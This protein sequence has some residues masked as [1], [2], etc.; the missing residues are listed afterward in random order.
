MG[1]HVPGFVVQL[2]H[3]LQGLKDATRPPIPRLYK[4]VESEMRFHV[5]RAQ[6][7][8]S[9]LVGSISRGHVL[10]FALRSEAPIEIPVN[11]NDQYMYNDAEAATHREVKRNEK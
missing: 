5:F 4:H 1:P 11:S 10:L 9:P 3:T 2:K 6:K 8:R 7:Q